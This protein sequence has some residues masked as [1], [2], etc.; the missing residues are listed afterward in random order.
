V[1]NLLTAAVLAFIGT[2]LVGAAQV[3]LSPRGRE[4]W[5]AVVRGLRVRHF[6]MAVP[7]LVLV[8][9]AVIVLV[10]LPVLSFGWWTALG[11]EG[12]PVVGSTSRTRGTP[13]ATIVPAVFLAFLVPTLPL[14][15]L[16]E[17]EV[18][19]AGSE[20]RTTT[21]R[22]WWAVKFGMVHALVGIPIGA[23]LALSIGGGYFTWMYLRAWRR[24]HSVALATLESAR[25]HVAYNLII[26]CLVIVVL[27][28]GSV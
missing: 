21:E 3:A 25:A 24:T 17:E 28:T 19:R 6:V 10:Q 11:G 20:L 16:R 22:V 8:F 4:R 15:A 27:A 2:R 13:L 12:N 7:V 1:T 14:F 23:A 26:V 18:F 5:L 9:A